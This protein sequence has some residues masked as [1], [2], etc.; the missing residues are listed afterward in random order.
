[1]DL[2]FMPRPSV[3]LLERRAADLKLAFSSVA[4]GAGRWRLSSR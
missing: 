2:A 3:K 4:L 1:M